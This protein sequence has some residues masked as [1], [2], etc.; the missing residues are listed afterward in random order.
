MKKILLVFCVLFLLSSCS[1]D[2]T[3]NNSNPL[4]KEVRATTNSSPLVFKYFYNG[5]K[6]TSIQTGDHLE[7]RY[8]YQGDLIVSLFIYNYGE[9]DVEAHY[10]YDTQD[11]LIK[12][13]ATEFQ[14]GS[15]DLRTY[16]YNN[17]NT[18]TRHCYSGLTASSSNLYLTSK[19]YLD[20][21][22]KFFNVEDLIASNWVS[23]LQVT[24]TD[25]N[26][27]LKNILGFD[28]I[29][30]L[31]DVNKSFDTYIDNYETGSVNHSSVFEYTVNA[32]NYPTQRTQ[33]LTNSDG[34]TYVSTY[35]FIYY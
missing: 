8:V 24:Y 21:T 4:I 25:I 20:T 18:I 30:L 17:D 35:E 23:T 31:S 7:N 10:E 27:P 3:G 19:I 33:T 5:N 29:I 1:S 9:L 14:E 34:S 13:T 6:I 12:E 11:R 26:S 28:K 16:T 2:S 22:G 15:S 32:S